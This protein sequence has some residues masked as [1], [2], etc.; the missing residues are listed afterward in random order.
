MTSL[1][2][3]LN[4]P[5]NFCTAGILAYH[6]RDKQQLAERILDQDATADS[7]ECGMDKGIIWHSHPALLQVR[8]S[9]TQARVSLHTDSTTVPAKE[10]L[11]AL[12]ER[13]LGLHQDVAAFEDK[14][15]NH[16]LLANLIRQ[17]PGLRIPTVASPFEAFAW[18][19][20]GQQI[21][22]TAAISIRS[23]LI[24]AAGVRHSSGMYCFPDATHISALSYQALRECGFSNSKANCLLNLSRHVAEKG[25]FSDNWLESL[26]TEKVRETLLSL[27]GIGP[28]T[29]NYGLLRGFGWLD[30]SLET[31]AAVRRNLAR[32]LNQDRIT[33]ARTAAWLAQFSPYRSLVAAHLWE[34]G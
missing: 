15:T 12:A 22:V 29:I 10:A 32:L 19:I 26:G 14:Y 7:Q 16:P 18:A 9:D 6:R 27:K 11:T 20:T 8:F 30:E 2:I 5:P 31:D 3:T 13:M 25:Y 34:M 21:S 23:K 17:N 33:P 24:Q 1:T 28:W 4:L